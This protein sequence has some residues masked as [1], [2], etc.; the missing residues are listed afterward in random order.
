MSLPVQ[1]IIRIRRRGGDENQSI[2]LLVAYAYVSQRVSAS[3]SGTGVDGGVLS[4]GPVV[5]SQSHWRHWS[6]H[7]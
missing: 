5:T 6:L 3:C 1:G 7:R 4:D 2:C